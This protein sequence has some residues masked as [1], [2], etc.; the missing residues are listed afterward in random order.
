MGSYLEAF[1][2]YFRWN[3]ST[4]PAVSIILCWPVKNGWQE[5]Q[6]STWSVLR[7]DRV[8]YTAPQVH[9]IAHS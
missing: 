1:F 7:V 8:W 5:A 3:F 6:I 4:R 2:V 9:V